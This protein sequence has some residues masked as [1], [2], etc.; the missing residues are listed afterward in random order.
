MQRLRFGA[1]TLLLAVA[2]LPLSIGAAQDDGEA[3]D[4]LDLNEVIKSSV[5]LFGCGDL[6]IADG[7]VS[8]DDFQQCEAGWSGSGT[9]VE[10]NGQILTNAHN[11][12]DNP[13]AA[14][15]NPVWVVVGETT[16]FTSYP[17]PVFIG[18]TV[19][20]DSRVDLAIVEPALQL[21]GTE[22]DPDDVRMRPMEMNTNADAVQPAQELQVL[23]YP[24]AGRETITFIPVKVVGF[25]IDE[26]NQEL[27]AGFIKYNPG[28]GPGMS[29][30]SLANA[31]GVL[32]GVHTEGSQSE[33]RCGDANNDGTVDPATECGAMGGEV[34]FARPIPE[35]YDLLLQRTGNSQTET[36]P[37]PPD[38]VPV[39][40][41]E[42]PTVGAEPTPASDPSSQPE[43]A[44]GEAII[45]GQV[46]SADTAEP[47]EGAL[48]LVLQ[49]GIKITSYLH[50]GKRADVFSF[51]YSDGQ[52]N[53]Q[54]PEP[55]VRGER[56]GVYVSAPGYE[57]VGK[58]ARELATADD[59]ET[60]EQ[61]TIK[62]P[63][64]R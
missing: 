11:V 9:I 34:G 33:I 35:G 23:G 29:G 5:W 19:A 8:L 44:S 60:V 21:D 12:L 16:D 56:Y 46:I 63:V 25:D 53:F 1:L 40:P 15:P 42:E 38:E 10:A 59:P 51:A 14:Q 20:F 18:R 32:V 2:L 6:P 24:S 41:A 58:D 64:Q 55:V 31:D 22:I 47:I 48:F 30:G 17:N 27:K 7:P 45:T 62:M 26:T 4:G 49:P 61:P 13:A 50:D 3:V 28:S 36:E 57:T 39:P 37:P 52:G 54:L 43:P